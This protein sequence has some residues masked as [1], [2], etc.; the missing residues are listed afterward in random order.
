MSLRATV[1]ASLC[2]VLSSLSVGCAAL[3]G[4]RAFVQPPRFEQDDQQRSEIRLNGTS[5]AAVRI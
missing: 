3:E 5:G 2:V 1:F 4:L